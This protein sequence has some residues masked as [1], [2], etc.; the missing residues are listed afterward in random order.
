MK[1]NVIRIIAVVLALTMLTVS[2]AGCSTSEVNRPVAV[3]T[4]TDLQDV[5]FEFTYGEL[6]GILPGDKLATLYE[7]FNKKTDD[8]VVKLSYYELISKYGSE[9]YFND[10]LNLISDE[11]W[12][13]FT[14]NQ[15]MVLDYF[16]GMINDIKTNGTARVSYN[17]S[18]W[19]NHGDG[20]VFK[21]EDGKELEDQDKFRAAFRIY[22]DMALKDIGKYL[23]NI[24]NEEKYQV[25]KIILPIKSTN[26]VKISLNS[27][28][29]FAVGG[30][31]FKYR[32]I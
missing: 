29:T 2:F 20:V 9:E 30:I 4:K 26:R 8:R 10:I 15:Q 12:A 19:V 23:M 5:Y 18:F 17:E 14:G 6:K 28:D 25:T 16:N 31:L 13:Q 7:N 27:K 21:S 32:P 11:E 3:E 24:S 22:A 1:K